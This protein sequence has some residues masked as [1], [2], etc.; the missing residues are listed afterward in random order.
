MNPKLRLMLS[1]AVVMQVFTPMAGGGGPQAVYAQPGV[2]PQNVSA[3]AFSAPSGYIVHGVHLNP[4]ASPPYY[5]EITNFNTAVGKNAGIV[6]Y[7]R[8]WDNATNPCDD[9]YLPRFVDPGAPAAPGMVGG[10]VVLLTWE[11]LPI[12][13]NPGPSDY[14][15]ILN[16]S[17]DSLITECANE[18]KA[19]SNKTFLIRFMHEFNTQDYPWRANAAYNVKADGTGDTEKFKQVWRY[20]HDKFT[21]AGATNVQWVW[22][23]NWGS[24]PDPSTPGYA[25]LNMHNFYP[26]GAYVDWIGLSGY[27]WYPFL[28]YTSNS[29]YGDVYDTVLTDLQCRYAK[30]IIHAEIG[31]TDSPS[32]NKNMWVTDA[33][34]KMQTYPLLRAVS[35][36]N[37][38]AYHNTDQADF[39]VWTNTNPGNYGGSTPYTTVPVSVTNTYATAVSDSSFTP[40]Y[41][42]SKLLN[43]P[44]T[45]CAADSVSTNGVLGARPAANLVGKTGVTTTSFQLGALGLSANTTFTVSGCP[46]GV[47]CTFASSGT[48]TSTMR[49]APWSADTLNISVGGGAALATS[50][51]TLTG[52]GTSTTVQLTVAQSVSQLYLPIVVK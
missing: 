41:D 42:S 52:G 18:L 50:T 28:G 44:M 25:W 47:T 19:W 12:L 37:D 16:G 45:R 27:N 6:M 33:Y 21:A 46:S 34:Q 35:W 43:P 20:V 11:P 32:G 30:P 8:P 4:V 1:L 22:S 7:F 23:P 17:Y 31:S 39:R 26:G 36:F 9:G 29:T 2:A 14:D 5:D 10:R 48:G 40:I 38:Y 49:T 51:L 13:A 24:N 15:N 3:L